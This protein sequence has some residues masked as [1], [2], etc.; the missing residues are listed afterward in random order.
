MSGMEARKR[1]SWTIATEKKVEGAAEA[2]VVVVTRLPIV[3][4]VQ[5]KGKLLCSDAI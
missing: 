5:D 3:A 1:T 4:G 2:G